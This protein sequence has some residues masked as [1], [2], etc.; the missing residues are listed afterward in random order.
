MILNFLDK[1]TVVLGCGI[2]IL[3]SL[4]HTVVVVIHH[5]GVLSADSISNK[6]MGDMLSRLLDDLWFKMYI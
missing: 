2:V 1:I 3:Y 4:N 6:R 5:N